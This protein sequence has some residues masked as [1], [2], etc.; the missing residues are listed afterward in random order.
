[1]YFFYFRGLSTVLQLLNIIDDWTVKLDS[2]GQID[3]IYMDF[4][5][6]F[7]KV[8]HRRFI[9]KLHSYGIHSKIILWITDFLDKRQFRVTVNGKFSSWHDVISGIPQ[10][11]ILGPL[12]FII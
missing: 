2:G 4:E 12:L 6:A 5:K 7:D 1:M 9:S 11:S 10:G 3:C 8:L